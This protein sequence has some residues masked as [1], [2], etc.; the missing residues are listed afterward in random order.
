MY[1]KY[2]GLKRSQDPNHQPKGITHLMIINFE[3]LMDSLN[4]MRDLHTLHEA[5]GSCIECHNPWPCDTDSY[6][7]KATKAFDAEQEL[8]DEPNSAV[9]LGKVLAAVESRIGLEGPWAE[10]VISKLH[11]LVLEHGI[12]VTGLFG[13]ETEYQVGITISE[14]SY[15]PLWRLSLGQQLNIEIFATTGRATSKRFLSQVLMDTFAARDASQMVAWWENND[16][17]CQRKLTL[18]YDDP[19]SIT[20]TILMLVEATIR[21]NNSV[22][23]QLHRD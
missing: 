12:D 15:Q 7:T 13:F 19:V 20:K 11:H 8:A 1:E 22:R 2:I 21:F 6:L 14:D 18:H 17:A 4:R 10:K 23:T 3:Y 5:T 9:E 16:D